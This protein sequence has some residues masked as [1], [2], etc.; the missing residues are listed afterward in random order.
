MEK[1]WSLTKKIFLFSVVL[2]LSNF[3]YS[4]ADLMI[5]PKRV[6]FDDVRDRVAVV[7]LFNRGK[8][9]TTYNLSFVQVR[10][11]ED[12]SF[13]N[14]IEPDPGQ[15]FASPYLRYYPRRVVLAPNEIQTVKIQLVKTNELRPG[16]YR[17]HL[18][19]RGIPENFNEKNEDSE[20]DEGGFKLNLTPIYGI[21]I[22]V[23]IKVG[24]SSTKVA[25][26]NIELQENETLAFN[27]SRQGNMSV[28]G[29][30]EVVFTSFGG[31]LETLVGRINGLAVYQPTKFREITLDLSGHEFQ[32]GELTVRYFTQDNKEILAENSLRI[33]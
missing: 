31:G 10:M 1:R 4:Q 33:D 23:I 21:A 29:N 26:E 13:T 20:V 25:V 15:N 16:E 7:E 12:G 28:Y 27:L 2:F 6:V 24:E 30:I 11:K 9:T 22:P 17:S 3:G 8:D 18:D 5:N 19:F 32:S 14:I